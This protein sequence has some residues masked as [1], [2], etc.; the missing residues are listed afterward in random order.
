MRASPVDALVEHYTTDRYRRFGDTGPAP[1][2]TVEAWA[3]EACA[4]VECGPVIDQQLVV[5]AALWRR[6]TELMEPPA[7]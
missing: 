5:G 2:G 7:H 1:E 3:A 4:T 6:A